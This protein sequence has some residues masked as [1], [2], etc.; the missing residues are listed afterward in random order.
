MC[1]PFGEVKTVERVEERARRSTV[2]GGGETIH[3]RRANSVSSV[4]KTK[5]S[6][7]AGDDFSKFGVGISLY[8]GEKDGCNRLLRGINGLF[9]R[10]TWVWW[11]WW[12]GWVVGV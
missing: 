7:F 5:K 10:G 9:T 3:G 4:K 11:W 8:V 2:A 6:Y 1:N 12:G